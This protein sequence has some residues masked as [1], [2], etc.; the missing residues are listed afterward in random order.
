[1]RIAL[2]CDTHWGVRND[3]LIMHNNMKKFLDNIFFPALEERGINTIIH[4]G[5]LVDRRKYI[6]YVTAKRLRQ[7]FLDPINE[8]NI[9]M[10]VIA[11]NHDTFYKNTNETNALVELIGDAKAVDPS[12]PIKSIKRYPNIHIHYKT[13]RELH[14]VGGGSILLM[15]WICD[16]NREESLE[17]IRES[18]SAIAMGHLEL[19][20]FE[21]YKGQLND[22]GDDPKIFDKFDLVCS[23]HYHT[24]SSSGNIHYLG[25]P[26]QY[27]WSDYV[28][29]KGFHILDTDTRSLEFIP[30]PVAAFCKY[31]Y[32]DLNKQM[33]EVL[34]FDANDYKDKYV[35]VIIKNKTNP[36]WFDLVID[37]FEKAGAADLQVVEDHFHL[38]LEEDSDIINEAEDTMSI[39]RK[40]IGGMQINTDRKRVENIIQELYIEAHNI[41]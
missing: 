19:A 5:D 14:I 26:C 2:I 22:H 18:R 33:D 15:P 35:K 4:L 31:H 40:F 30:N 27:T 21:M 41:E 17:A 16:E 1:M 32:D 24:K 29:T 8:R 12:D 3:S 36:Y 13:P 10:H 28:D 25:T 9:T 6:N 23:G 11:G 37:R 20:G 7:D 38:D 39:V 34:L